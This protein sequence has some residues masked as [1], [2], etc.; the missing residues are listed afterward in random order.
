MPIVRLTFF[1]D[2]PALSKRSRKKKAPRDTM[3]EITADRPPDATAIASIAAVIAIE[4]F[5]FFFARIEMNKNKYKKYVDIFNMRSMGSRPCKSMNLNKKS[6]CGD[7]QVSAYSIKL[8]F[9]YR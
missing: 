2:L 9:E 8:L 4:V 6:S 7:V 5:W 1:V 3:K